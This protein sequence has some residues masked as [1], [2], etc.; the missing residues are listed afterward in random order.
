MQ[1]QNG[2]FIEIV[3]TGRTSGEVFDSN[4]PE[5]LNKINSQH[6]P[7]KTIVIIGEKMV[8][9][10]LDEAL[11]NREIGASFTVHVEPR[12][13]FGERQTKLVRPI[14]LK[15]FT[16]RKISPRIGMALLLD[17]SLVTIRAV[18]G[19]RVIVDFNSPLAGKDLDYD[20]TITRKV[21]DIKEKADLFFE[22][23]ARSKPELEIAEAVTVKIP[24][25]FEPFISLFKPK[26]K[27][28]IG[29]EL[30]VR[31]VEPP[32]NEVKSQPEATQ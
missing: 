15:V 19:A 22:W 24:K 28:L 16:D 11:L 17:Q 1:T 21:D 6:Q 8:V 27:T 3:F 4:N 10:G 9:P 31:I 2:D 23:F 5:E 7:R 29:K 18:S 12:K 25:Q 30:I 26:F 14:P 13:G 32:A 20:V